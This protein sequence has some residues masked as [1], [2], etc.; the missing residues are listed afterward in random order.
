[1]SFKNITINWHEPKTKLFYNICCGHRLYKLRS[2]SATCIKMKNF[3]RSRMFARLMHTHMFFLWSLISIFQTY[4]LPP[5]RSLFLDSVYQ[6]ICTSTSTTI[7]PPFGL[8]LDI[9]GKIYLL[10]HITFTILPCFFHK[11]LIILISSFFIPF[12]ISSLLKINFSSSKSCIFSIYL[13]VDRPLGHKFFIHMQYF[14]FN[15]SNVLNNWHC[16]ANVPNQQNYIV[17]V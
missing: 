4:L 2:V 15:S 17:T 7:F 10:Q 16:V 13:T 5:R 6:S 9:P 11:W 14:E 8:V 12:T 1:M 3:A